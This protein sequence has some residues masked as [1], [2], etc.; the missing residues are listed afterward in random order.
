MYELFVSN[1]AWIA[2]TLYFASILPQIWLNYKLKSTAGLSDLM[3]IGYIAGYSASFFYVF[4]LGLPL[5]YKI[6][7]PISFAVASILM[8]QR[9]HYAKSPFQTRLLVGY[10]SVAI[11]V[12]LLIPLAYYYPKIVGHASGWFCAIIWTVYQI[13]QIAKIW[14]TGSVLGFSFGL[15]SIIVIGNIVELAG[16]VIGGFPFQTVLIDLR[17]LLVYVIFCFQFWYFSSK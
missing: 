13:P 17:G 6:L 3:I 10:F 12:M 16:A 14:M 5:A 1:V 15:P 4:L 8:F 2:N 7:V 11:V 9:F